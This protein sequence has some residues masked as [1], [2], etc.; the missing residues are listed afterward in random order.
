MLAKRIDRD[1]G[2]DNYRSLGKYIADASHDGEKLLFAWHAGCQSETYETALM[3][4]EATQEINT[5]CK[6]EKTYHLMVSF[7]P[8][9]EPKLTSETFRDIEL[10]FAESLGFKDHQ[11]L[12]GVHRNTNNIH[13]HIAYNM[14]HPERYTKMEPFRDFYR[15]S[16]ACRAMEEKYGL[17][18]DNG[19]TKANSSQQIHQ[20][21]A[22]ME[23]HSGEQSFQSYV[24]SHTEGILR[25]MEGATS[26]QDVHVSL[27]EY[28]I[29]IKPHGN[30]MAVVNIKGKEAIKASAIDRSLSKKRLTDR[31]GEYMTPL[32]SPAG[33]VK[34]HYNRK[35]LQAKSPERDKL[36]EEYKRLMEQQQA[37]I[38]A[39]KQQNAARLQ[40]IKELYSEERKKLSMQFYSRS[41]KT[42]LRHILRGQEYKAIEDSRATA[43]TNMSTIKETT[44]FHNWNGFLK[45]Q[46]NRG[47]ET[48]LAVLRSRKP[49][50]PTPVKGKD[51]QAYY[52][53]RRDIRLRVLEDQEKIYATTI[54]W[55]LRNR[56]IAISQMKQLA[57][58]E[59]LRIKTGMGDQNALFSGVQH[60][61]DNNGIV[62]FKL[63]SGGTIRDAGKKIFF[64]IDETT[65]NAAMIYSQMRFGKRIKI[66]DN[67]VEQKIYGRNQRNRA[68]DYQPVLTGIKEMCGHG[69]RTLSQLDVV[70]FGKRD[71]VLLPDHARGDLER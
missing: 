1:P 17:Q 23:A 21:A 35:P 39:V 70:R 49:A 63:A 60:V 29:M 58:Q 57:A 2:Y 8:E 36:Y 16:E 71:K 52:E 47:N 7:R 19:I 33:S 59:T 30:G 14:I 38:E 24:M 28:G 11:R 6:G 51:T 25:T 26:W 31:F 12:C 13:M 18:I 44:P 65:R 37:Q 56:L 69:L 20:R 43:Q 66:K 4:I 68:G 62:I 3:E 15:L 32:D 54:R 67:I 34:H 55:K 50:P 64:S 10:A 48:A 27:A 9:D 45:W 40:A 42:R 61:I 46:A 5:R 41:T 53:E 22:S